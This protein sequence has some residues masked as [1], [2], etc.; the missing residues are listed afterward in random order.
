MKFGNCPKSATQSTVKQQENTAYDYESDFE[1]DNEV[2]AADQQAA[3]LK[4]LVQSP[5]VSIRI[6]DH[7]VPYL[8]NFLSGVQVAMTT[9]A[10]PAAS[11]KKFLVHPMW[12]KMRIIMF[13]AL[14]TAAHQKVSQKSSLREKKI[15]R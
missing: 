12:S 3:T 7:Q 11:Q 4:K 13:S 6:A 14:W 5:Q 9:V 15:T 8:K 1:N 10:H 2:K